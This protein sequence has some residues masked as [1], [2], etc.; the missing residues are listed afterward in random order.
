MSRRVLK[1][2]LVGRRLL[3]TVCICCVLDG[4]VHV[5]TTTQRDSPYKKKVREFV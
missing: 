3:Y 1:Q 4:N 2:V 5:F